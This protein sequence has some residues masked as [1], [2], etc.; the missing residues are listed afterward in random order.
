MPGPTQGSCVSVSAWVPVALQ[1]SQ[2][3]PVPSGWEP[4]A[5]GFSAMQVPSHPDALWTP[6][7]AFRLPLAECPPLP[8]PGPRQCFCFLPNKIGGKAAKARL[9]TTV[10]P[11]L[12]KKRQKWVTAT[13]LGQSGKLCPWSSATL[14]F[15]NLG[16]HRVL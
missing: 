16:M 15:V 12:P 9:T 4:L 5:R 11:G 10:V 1:A 7:V 13:V 2:W 3:F 8:V 6:D 14:P